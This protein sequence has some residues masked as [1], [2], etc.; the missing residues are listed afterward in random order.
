ME[1]RVEEKKSEKKEEK[2][3]RFPWLFA[4]MV[5]ALLLQVFHIYIS[6]PIK[7]GHVVAP[8]IWLSKCGLL[9]AMNSCENSYFSMDKEGKMTVYGA[10]R[11][12]AWEAQGAVCAEGDESCTPGMEFK[13]DGSIVIG[14]KP[15]SSI[16]MYQK[17]ELAPWP[18]A[19]KPQVRV[20]K[21]Y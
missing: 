16:T 17:S 7:P 9:A 5:C 20:W 4:V 14:G 11:E 1:V 3:G 8:G 18:F 21:K 12:V 13:E 6:A 10:D 15:I 2:G 19:E